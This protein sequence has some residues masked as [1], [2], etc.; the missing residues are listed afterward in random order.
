MPNTT[1][2]ILLVSAQTASFQ[3]MRDFCEDASAYLDADPANT[4]V[5]HCKAG[6]GRTGLMICALLIHKASAGSYQ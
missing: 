6:K 1:N 5:V 2:Y 4:A 3:L